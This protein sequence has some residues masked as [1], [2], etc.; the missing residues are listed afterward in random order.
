M[1]PRDD[2]V[3][4]IPGKLLTK[5]G[6]L[7]MFRAV[8]PLTGP[9]HQVEDCLAAAGSWGGWGGSGVGGSSGWMCPDLSTEQACGCRPAQPTPPGPSWPLT[10]RV[11]ASCRWRPQDAGEGRGLRLEG[12]LEPWGRGGLSGSARVDPPGQRMKMFLKGGPGPGNV[13]TRLVMRGK[14]R[15]HLLQHGFGAPPFLKRNPGAWP[16]SKLPRPVLGQE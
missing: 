16:G 1:Y 2:K 3:T 13:G 12:P 15:A 8:A 7:G 11:P 6:G 10:I 9:E 14:G 5:E 4:A